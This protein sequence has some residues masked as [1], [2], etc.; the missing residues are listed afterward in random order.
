[1]AKKKSP[2]YEYSLEDVAIM[3]NNLYVL[4]V[5]EDF[6]LQDGHYLFTG[7]EV[8]KLYNSTLK[9]LKDAIHNGSEKDKKFAL[10]LISGLLIK[11]MR[12]H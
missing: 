4:E 7:K 9:D 12:L 1:M 8:S 3:E 6:V 2:Y 5:D 10:H 11:P